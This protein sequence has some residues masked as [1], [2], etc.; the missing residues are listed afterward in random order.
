VPLAI[1][2]RTLSRLRD[3]LQQGG[4]RESDVDSP[5]FATLARA[6]MTSAIETEM[7]A[8]VEPLAEIMFL[9]MASDGELSQVEEE[10]FRGAVRGM[11]DDAIH[12]GTVTV[13]LERFYNRLIDVGRETRLEEIAQLIFDDRPRAEGAFV[14]SA[15]VA[16][17]DRDISES[18]SEFLDE[19]A[20]SLGIDEARARELLEQLD[21][22]RAG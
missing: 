14:L 11:S 20:V 17:A 18:E 6:G 12:P 10:V 5:A 1:D 9:T 19:L 8:R 7:V 4:A 3:N 21:Q 15:A 16:Y 22:D 2:P 13:M